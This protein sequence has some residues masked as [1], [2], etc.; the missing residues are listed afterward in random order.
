MQRPNRQ[1]QEHWKSTYSHVPLLAQVIAHTQGPILELGCGHGSTPLIHALCEPTCRHVVSA[2]DDPEWLGQ[3]ECYRQ[4]WHD[5]TLIPSKHH[6]KLLSW[7][8]GWSVVFVDHGNAEQR[9]DSITQFS[10]GEAD[11]V[12]V[13]DATLPYGEPYHYE[14][15]FS[16]FAHRYIYTDYWPHTVVLSQHRPW[17]A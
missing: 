12:V 7:G 4:S 14:R 11:W 10:R 2:D 17:M 9:N 13:H 5:L 8:S 1:T 3:F 15:S 16:L 6:W